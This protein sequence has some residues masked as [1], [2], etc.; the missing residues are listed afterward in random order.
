M[1]LFRAPFADVAETRFA[2]ESLKLCTT[3]CGMRVRSTRLLWWLAALGC[4][5]AG[6]AQ[7]RCAC[8]D[9]R[10]FS[11]GAAM[12]GENSARVM[13]TGFAPDFA[14]SAPESAKAPR[15]SGIKVVGQTV[16][17]G[18]SVDGRPFLK[19][20][21]RKRGVIHDVCRTNIQFVK[22]DK[23]YN[24]FA[25]DGSAVT[26]DGNTPATPTPAAADSSDYSQDL[27]G[28]DLL[29]FDSRSRPLNPRNSAFDQEDLKE[30]AY[31][32]VRRRVKAPAYGENGRLRGEA[33]VNAGTLGRIEKRAGSRSESMWN[34][35][36]FPD[37]A[38]APFWRSVEVAL[39]H[40]RPASNR[41][42]LASSQIVE[43]NHF[44]DQYRIE[45]TRF[46]KAVARV[47]REPGTTDLPQI[48]ARPLL[49][50]AENIA[51]AQASGVIESIEK[52]LSAMVLTP[53][54]ALPSASVVILEASGES[55]NADLLR[56][57]CFV[58]AGGQTVMD[59]GPLRV[60]RAGVK[61]FRPATSEQV[62]PDYYAIDLDLW[63]QSADSTRAR[64]VCRFP[65]DPIGMALVDRT[66]KILA[67][68]FEVQP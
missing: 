4:A 48:F 8:A 43:I 17:L 33:D 60:S 13:V 11:I 20:E 40:S 63:L 62:S 15:C 28:Q 47:K 59:R 35:E 36:L 5:A 45:V 52:A 23:T 58:Q 16:E 12:F 37:S 53:K 65:F 1:P 34:V 38:P 29:H 41:V 7:D 67:T 66:R 42:V 10:M 64:V 49:P 27:T 55:R 22:L 44:F 51:D 24:F 61:V 9:G 6:R 21:S 32:I 68:R 30:T 25:D 14:E 18:R 2:L 46:G 56:R 50:L 57:Q 19:R 39:G 54:N 26:L 3:G 31:V